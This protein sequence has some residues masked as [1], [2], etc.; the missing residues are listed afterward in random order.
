M[1]ELE[2]RFDPEVGL[3]RVDGNDSLRDLRDSLWYALSLL[4][5]GD[6]S[7]RAEDIIRR[8]LGTQ[9]SDP[10]DHY[11][12]NFRWFYE[13]EPVFDLNAVEFMLERL[14]HILLRV[15]DRLSAP[16]RS[17][18]H[19]SMRLGFEE[20][21]RLD[22]HWSYTNIFLLDAH[23]SILGGQ[24][25]GDGALVQR[26]VDRLQGWFN[27]TR[28]QGAPHEFNSPTY[29]AVQII[30]LAA[31]AQFAEDLNVRG[32]A[33]EA[34]QFL[35]MHVA[36]HFHAPTLQLAGPHSRAYRHDVT[37]SVG[38]LKVVLYKVLGDEWL[39]AP[40][41]YY[42]GPGREGDIIVSLTDFNPPLEAMKMLRATEERE[43][44]ESAAQHQELVTYLRPE[45]ALGTMSREYSVGEPPEPWPQ[46]N[47]CL[48][49][50][51]KDEPPGYGVLYCRYL[52]NDRRA[53]DS[54]Y[55]SSGISVDLWDDGLFRTAQSGRAAIVAYGTLPHGR[56]PVHSLRLDIRMLGPHPG[57]KVLI[58][59]Q[60]WDGSE[61]IVAAGQ[62]LTVS[63]GDVH[64]GVIPLEAD[65]LSSDGPVLLWND[66]QEL[67]LSIY[68]YRGPP[69]STWE[70]RSLSGPFYRGNVRNGF[71]VLAETNSNMSGADFACLLQSA[72][73]DDR[74]DAGQ[75]RIAFDSAFGR[76]ALEYDLSS[77][78]L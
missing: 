4:L 61:T 48:L 51:R 18:I 58:D 63:D 39:L 37:G 25:L 34:E 16:S 45:F 7:D 76:V 29:S 74:L 12:G 67:V 62:R 66:G 22:V 24:L 38:F 6:S 65:H 35:W 27:R 3:V 13:V 70:Y 59:G 43:V 44:V 2:R 10:N 19:D 55:A 23:N 31:I 15:S 41:P 36:R 75:R 11:R 64:I 28:S 47:S 32:L 69:K 5:R 78:R 54:V 56:R 72:S 8:V 50:Y 57:A 68:N 52:I 77:M 20:V 33:M 40:A 26:G 1:R 49:T 30:A 14:V 42:T 46:H 53:G 21:R 17:L 9:V 73:V 71:I 60:P